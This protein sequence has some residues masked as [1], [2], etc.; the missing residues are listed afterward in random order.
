[1]RA[2]VLLEAVAVVGAQNNDGWTALM[3]AAVNGHEQVAR[4]LLEA[5]ADRNPNSTCGMMCCALM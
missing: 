3:Y 4:V 2:R 1:M 5:G